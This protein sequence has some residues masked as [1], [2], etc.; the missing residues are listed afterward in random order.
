M[1][2]AESPEMSK[3]RGRKHEKQTRKE[4]KDLAMAA[5]IAAFMKKNNLF[6]SNE[7]PGS[8]SGTSSSG[9]DSSDSE[10]EKPSP[11]K[12]ARSD[13]QPPVEE[14]E[15]KD[16]SK[17][18]VTT[19]PAVETGKLSDEKKT[20]TSSVE[21]AD[22]KG[23]PDTIPSIPVGSTTPATVPAVTVTGSSASAAG[24]LAVH[25]NLHVRYKNGSIPV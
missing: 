19:S 6:D 15:R 8:S 16:N 10:D 12:K 18:K 22:K 4:R 13:E 23:N 1:S 21:T 17:E 5:A 9:T 3:K 20:T 7:C 11:S 25:K 14:K 2:T 24:P